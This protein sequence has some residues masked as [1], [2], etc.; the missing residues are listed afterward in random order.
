MIFGLVV[1]D[2]F[3]IVSHDQIKP[4]RNGLTTTL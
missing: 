4:V 3:D 2:F 1:T